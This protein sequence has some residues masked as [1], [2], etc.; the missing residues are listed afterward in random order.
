MMSSHEQAAGTRRFT[1]LDDPEPPPPGWRIR[2]LSVLVPLVVVLATMTA[3]LKPAPSAHHHARLTTPTVVTLTS[4]ALLPGETYT[5]A[6]SL[7]IVGPAPASPSYIT[8]TA[9]IR[10]YDR[11]HGVATRSGRKVLAA[12]AQLKSL[13]GS[14]RAHDYNLWIVSV[15]FHPYAGD[16]HTWCVDNG[17]VNAT[18]GAPSGHLYG[19]PLEGGARPH[20]LVRQ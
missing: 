14:Y 1:F 11:I 4:G 3:V 7:R 19:C 6:R 17:F 5:Q 16:P 20:P 10:A 9:A 8:R 2:L 13:D 18:T 12:L 15:W